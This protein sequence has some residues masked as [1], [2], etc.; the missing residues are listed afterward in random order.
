MCE[1][2]LNYIL[3]FEKE[4]ENFNFLVLKANNMDTKTI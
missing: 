1:L 2:N 3:L 4:I